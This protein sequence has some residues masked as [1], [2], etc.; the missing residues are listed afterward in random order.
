MRTPI[1]ITDRRR[2][3]GF[4]LIEVLAA[5]TIFAMATAVVGANVGRP[6]GALN[7]QVLAGETASRARMVRDRAIRSG[8]DGVLLLDLEARL[9]S[10]ASAG[11]ALTIARE[12]DVNVVVA[13]QERPA[14]ATALIRFFANGMSTGGTIR[15]GHKGTSYEVRVNWLNGRVNV[16]RLP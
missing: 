8:R 14:P 11:K 9:V 5:L 6:S 15:Y 10:G 16:E 12:I 3:G 13:S 2:D 7:V 1:S 4:T